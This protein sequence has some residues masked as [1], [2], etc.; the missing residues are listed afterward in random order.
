MADLEITE[1][2]NGVT[3]AVFTVTLEGWT[4]QTVAV[5][6]YTLNA[7][8]AAPGDF[9]AT[10][11]TLVFAPGA[12]ARDR[13]RSGQAGYRAG[14]GRILFSRLDKPGQRLPQHRRRRAAPF[15][16]TTACRAN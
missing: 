10:N 5:D 16:M 8:A 4:E 12:F 3:E 9:M 1:G 11:G 13:P 15:S 6:F 14:A 2:N 7:T